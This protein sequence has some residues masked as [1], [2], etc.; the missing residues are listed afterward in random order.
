MLLMA[1]AMPAFHAPSPVKHATQIKLL[2]N[3]VAFFQL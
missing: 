1:Q 3:H 2:V